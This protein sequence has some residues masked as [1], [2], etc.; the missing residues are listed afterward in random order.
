MGG[1]G[2][3]VQRATGMMSTLHNTQQ[4][5]QFDEAYSCRNFISKS[6]AVAVGGGGKKNFRNPGQQKR[7]LNFLKL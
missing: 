5:K 7:V 1:G 6:M 4:Q 2:P 3:E